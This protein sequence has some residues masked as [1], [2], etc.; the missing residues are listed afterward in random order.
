MVLATSVA[1]VPEGMQ[2]EPESAYTR[3]IYER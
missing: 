3:R 2:A 1:I